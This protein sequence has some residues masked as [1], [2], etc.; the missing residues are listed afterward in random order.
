LV[1]EARQG[2]NRVDFTQKLSVANKEAIKTHYWLRLLR[3]SDQISE[4]QAVSL[5][6]DCEELQKILISSPKTSRAIA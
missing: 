2:E 1:E 6:K 4:K 5:L 3:D